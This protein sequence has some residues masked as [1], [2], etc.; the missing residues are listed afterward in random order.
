MWEIVCRG[1]RSTDVGQGVEIFEYDDFGHI[2]RTF[3]MI[4][5]F[6]NCITLCNSDLCKNIYERSISLIKVVISGIAEETG[7]FGK[8]TPPFLDKKFTYQSLQSALNTIEI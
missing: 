5:R 1:H 4:R 7:V 2:T 8:K 6:C 3:L